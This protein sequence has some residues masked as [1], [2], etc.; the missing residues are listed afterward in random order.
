MP[1]NDKTHAGLEP[2]PWIRRFAGLIPDGG[3]V[4]DV[5]CGAGRH[6]RMM[7]GLGHSVVALDRD[8]SKLEDLR[9]K[10][11]IEIV[12]AD[13][14]N[15][16]PWP[17]PDRRFSG[18]IVCNYLFR[19]VLPTLFSAL[20]DG[21]VL[22]YETFALGNERFG[23]P[24]NPAFLLKPGELLAAVKDRLRVVAFED[25]MVEQPRPAVIQRLCAIRPTDG[26][27]PAIL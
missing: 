20:A 5:A 15:G 16:S 21:G 14:E 6:T 12:K 27:S 9:A 19:P 18:I 4:L 3:E 11:G 17:L 1:T 7:H 23:K 24:S 22:L 10:P 8:V 13:L 25:G 2:S 26:M